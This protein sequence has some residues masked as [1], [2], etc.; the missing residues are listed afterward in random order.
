VLSEQQMQ[1]FASS[2]MSSSRETMSSPSMPISPSSLTMTAVR[3]PC[4][5]VRMCFTSVVFPLPRKP[6]MTVTGRRDSGG[7]GNAEDVDI[8]GHYFA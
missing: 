2:T 8:I 7:R 3:N 1:P 5:L 4:A 6:V